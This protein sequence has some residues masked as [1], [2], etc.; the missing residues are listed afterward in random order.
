M[1]YDNISSDQLKPSPTIRLVTLLV[2]DVECVD[3]K[4][5]RWWTFLFPDL[6]QIKCHFALQID[7]CLAKMCCLLAAPAWGVWWWP[8]DAQI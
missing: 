7:G 5:V 6:N 3:M 1:C 8:G 4:C 2:F